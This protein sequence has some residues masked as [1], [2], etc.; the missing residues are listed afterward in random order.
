MN[1]LILG[2]GGR[3]HALAEAVA[4]SARVGTVAVAPGNAGTAEIAQNISLD[5]LNPESVAEAAA[6]LG[7]DLVVIGP[8]A[9]LAAGVSDVLRARGLR[10]FGPSRAAARLE[11]SK[12]FAREVC[13]AAG[14]P[15]ARWVR[16]DTVD[17]ALAHV[18]SAELPIVVKADGLAAGKGVVVVDS[19]DE[20]RHAVREFLGGRFGSAGSTI[21]IESF[22]VGE[23][24]SFF[25]LCDGHRAVA[26]GGAEDYKRAR[27]GDEGPNTGGM[28]CCAPAA[29]LDP[30]AEGLVMDRIVLPCLWEMERRGTPYRG[31]LY[32]GL[33]I[34][35]GEPSVVEFN[36]RFGDPEC[37]ALFARLRS[38]PLDLLEP[39]S[40]GEIGN[41]QAAWDPGAAL[42]V[43]MAAPGYPDSPERGSEISGIEAA[44]RQPG[45]RVHHAGTKFDG[46]R[47]LAAGGRVLNVT[48]VGPTLTEARDRAYAGVAAIEWPEGQF[49]RDIGWRSLGRLR[50]KGS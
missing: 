18:N 23:E 28:G 46:A 19:R 9:P 36:A 30:G 8:E 26:L 42:T 43:V 31:V 13:D 29:V 44:R 7:A 27:D 14:I 35:R 37:Q 32:V 11:V 39:A 50:S 49:R 25:A 3:E 4:C 47:L 22:L 45:V 16:F 34:H 12:S 15:S 10:V 6:Y 24:A 1:I 40:D 20:A 21:V 38:D 48:A 33:M 2:S 5:V 41:V 17:S